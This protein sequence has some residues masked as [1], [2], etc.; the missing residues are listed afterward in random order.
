MTTYVPTRTYLY[1]RVGSSVYFS[2]YLIFLFSISLLIGVTD[3]GTEEKVDSSQLI[4]K[5]TAK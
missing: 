2:K 4:L 3:F 5:E 1:T